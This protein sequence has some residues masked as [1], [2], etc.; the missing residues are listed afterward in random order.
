MIKADLT[1][2]PNNLDFE[3]Y[4]LKQY[5][6]IGDAIDS[7]TSFELST[8]LNYLGINTIDNFNETTWEPFGVPQLSVSD[9]AKLGLV[10]PIITNA[11]Q[12]DIL[13]DILLHIIKRITVLELQPYLII[14]PDQ[15][16]IGVPEKLVKFKVD[17]N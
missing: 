4:L 1:Y 14:T 3:D 10:E 8:T 13:E 15:S 9:K 17:F 2:N 5:R 11:S 12:H 7:S 16:E 6:I